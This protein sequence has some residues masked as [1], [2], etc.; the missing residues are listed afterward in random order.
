MGIIY[1]LMLMATPIFL[2]ACQET[3]PKFEVVSLAV[4]PPEITVGEQATVRAEIR[5]NGT[6][7]EIYDVP[8]MINGV[9][10][11]RDFVSLAPGTSEPVTFTLV[12]HEPGNYKI[13][14][15]DKTSTLI[16]KS[17]P[18][19]QL[20]ELTVS[21]VEVSPGES[22]TITVRVANT[23]GT[24]GKYITPLKINGAS[25]QVLV[26][27]VAAGSSQTLTFAVLKDTPGTYMVAID[28]LTGQF[29]VTEPVTIIQFNIDNPKCPPTTPGSSSRGC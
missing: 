11:E 6:S 23:G 7:V 10:E 9:T 18:E 29:V 20:S 27:T 25:E 21:P 28:K 26:A 4:T 12:K 17:P 22:V 3:P 15:G 5:N 19:F 1:L 13:D 16:V 2:Q 24:D 8:L 14:I